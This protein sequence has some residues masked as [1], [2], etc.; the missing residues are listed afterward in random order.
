MQYCSSVSAYGRATMRYAV[1]SERVVLP[2]YALAMLCPVLTSR[3]Q[4]PLRF[5][6]LPDGG[7]YL[8]TECAPDSPHLS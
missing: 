7:S 5:G 6:D 2:A 4:A 1:L 3:M 8:I